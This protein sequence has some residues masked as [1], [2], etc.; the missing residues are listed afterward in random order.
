[1]NEVPEILRK[2]S[3]RHTQSRTDILGI[4]VA[5]SN[6]LSEREIESVLGDACDRVTIY[7]TLTTFLEKG[8]LHKVPDNE[9][10]MK[11]ALCPS[12]CHSGHSHR[13]DHV[14]FKCTQCGLTRCVEDVRIPG[15]S[16]PDGYQLQEV[17][18]LLQGLCPDCQ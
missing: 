1:M 4:F 5:R 7:R 16:L 9:G 18:M 14:H 2:H 17:S 15:V 6:A 13:H 8:I 11:Y 12:D 3:L 10:L